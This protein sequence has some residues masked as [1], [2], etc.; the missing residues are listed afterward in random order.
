MRPWR[1]GLVAVLTFWALFGLFLVMSHAKGMYLVHT[2]NYGVL[3]DCQQDPNGATPCIAGTSPDGRDPNVLNEP[4]D[5][6]Y[7]MFDGSPEI[8]IEATYTGTV[9]GKVEQ[10][11]DNGVT[12]RTLRSGSDP[13]TFGSLSSPMIFTILDP[14]GWYRTSTSTCT[15]CTWTTTY[16]A[17]PRFHP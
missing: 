3:Q 11:V 13:N 16:R 5:I 10:S 6:A 8:V 12:W 9:V 17:A 7:I 4:N 2:D 1:V 14:I 15:G